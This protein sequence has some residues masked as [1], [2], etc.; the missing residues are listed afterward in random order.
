MYKWQF[1]IEMEAGSRDV[2]N[3][4]TTIANSLAR[5]TLADERFINDKKSDLTVMGFSTDC[6]DQALKELRQQGILFTA[7]QTVSFCPGKLS[8]YYYIK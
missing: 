1:E 6:I 3:E 5:L 8:C 4:H 2:E 7:S